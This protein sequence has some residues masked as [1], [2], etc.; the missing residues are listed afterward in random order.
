MTECIVGSENPVKINAAQVALAKVLNKSITITPMAVSSGVADQPL[1]QEDTRQ[2]AINRINACV[3]N[4]SQSRREH[5][6]F[7]AI[8]GGV[9]H[10]ADGPATFAYVAIYHQGIWSVNRG[11]SLPLPGIIYQ[12]LEEGRELG[13]VM[14]DVFATNNVKQKEGA[15][16]LLT[17]NLATRQSVYESVL[18]LAL[19]KFNHPQLYGGI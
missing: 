17:N 19:A 3:N 10:F 1:S 6:W 15:I 18:I 16:G 12:A 2:G 14:D 13:D 11:A 5:S 8:E 7:V 4:V 9:D